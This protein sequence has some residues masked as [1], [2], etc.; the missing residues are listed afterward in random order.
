MTRDVSLDNDGVGHKRRPSACR[1]TPQRAADLLKQTSVASATLGRLASLKT[2]RR[3][4]RIAISTIPALVLLSVTAP[5]SAARTRHAYAAKCPPPNSHVLL[6]NSEA[7]LYIVKERLRPF[8]E[9]EPV[10]RGCV[11]GS[12]RSYLIGGAE[13]HPGGSERGGSSSVKLEALAGS[14]VAYTPAGN[15]VSNGKG[16]PE[17]L[18]VVRNLRTGRVLHEV[19]TGALAKPDVGSVGPIESI[20]VKSDGSVSWIVGTGYPNDIEYHVYAIDQSGSRLL[21]SGSNIEPY[22]LA[23]A[24]SALYWTRGGQPFSAQLN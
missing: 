12:K 15:Y 3:M 23:L 19:T 11:Y 20:V 4:R 7:E 5:P 14:V 8:P 18:M 6:A 24:G 13:E 9:P 1:M 22:S 17:A 21:A 16:Q 10:V 2:M